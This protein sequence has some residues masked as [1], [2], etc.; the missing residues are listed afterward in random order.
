[1]QL[2]PKA[3]LRNARVTIANAVPSLDF[4]IAAADEPRQLYG[5]PLAVALGQQADWITGELAHAIDQ[6]RQA[7]DGAMQHGAGRAAE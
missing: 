6:I 2:S 5:D 3:H 7:Q 4:C 1:M